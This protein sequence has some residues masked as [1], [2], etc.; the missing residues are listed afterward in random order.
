MDIKKHERH[1]AQGKDPH[2]I[3]FETLRVH[4]SEPVE[5][6]ILDLMWRNVYFHS[7]C[8]VVTRPTAFICPLKRQI[9]Y[10]RPP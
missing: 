6:P 2:G 5:A 9:K 10:S 4:R 3:F 8:L 7:K 1:F